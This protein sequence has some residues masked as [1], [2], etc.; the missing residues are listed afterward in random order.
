MTISMTDGDETKCSRSVHEYMTHL[1]Q[2]GRKPGALGGEGARALS[3]S[4]TALLSVERDEIVN[5][6][7]TPAC[8]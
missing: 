7:D 3:R 5:I 8:S 1:G 2:T 4:V 6:L